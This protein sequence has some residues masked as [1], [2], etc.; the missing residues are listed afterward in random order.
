[1]CNP[2][3]NNFICE[4]T[5]FLYTS[6]AWRVVVEIDLSAYHDT[7]S[8][9]RSGMNFEQQKQEFKPVYELKHMDS[10]LKTLDARL[11]DFQ[12]VLS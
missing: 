1:M 2:Y 8:V 4:G 12:Q 5:E 11:S 10:F 9:I 7:I 6:D 3:T